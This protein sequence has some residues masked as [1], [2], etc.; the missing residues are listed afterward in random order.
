MVFECLDRPLKAYRE[1]F[2]PLVFAVI[3]FETLVFIPWIISFSLMGKI[4]LIFTNPYLN[5]QMIKDMQKTLN[6]FVFFT[7]FS[8]LLYISFETGLV[9]VYETALK[10]KT[11][12]EELFYTTKSKWSYAIVAN[13]IVTG[14]IIGFWILTSIIFFLILGIYGLYLS[15]ILVSLFSIFFVFIT[16]SISIGNNYPMESVKESFELVKKNFID[17]TL[18]L[19]LAG[20]IFSLSLL[21]LFIPLIGE[22]V[23]ALVYFVFVTPLVGL[24]ITDAYLKY[25]EP[26]EGK[27]SSR[28]A[29]IKKKR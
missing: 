16:Q 2:L 24:M 13:F 21:L 8:A 22:I 1:Q 25:T 20:L 28:K 3:I 9:K 14:I 29:K 19:T 10:G 23:F 11:K 15:L 4:F 27:I 12:W 17:I 5:V 26:K 18:I 6:M 7:F